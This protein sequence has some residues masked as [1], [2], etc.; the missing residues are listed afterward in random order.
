[1]SVLYINN[2]KKFSCGD[3]VSFTNFALQMENTHTKT[4][5]ILTLVD[6][7]ISAKY[8][9][10]LKIGAIQWFG[11]VVVSVVLLV[12]MEY[13][14][15]L[16][17]GVKITMLLLTSSTVIFELYWLTGRHWL[18][19]KGFLNRMSR[20]DAAIEL[21]EK[22]PAIQDQLLNGIQLVEAGKN[23]SLVE[24]AL[25]KKGL[26][27]TQIRLDDLFKRNV[28]IRWLSAGALSVL[29]ILSFYLMNPQ[30]ITEGSQRFFSI[31][32]HY[33]ETVPYEFELVGG[34]TRKVTQG[35]DE[36]LEIEFGHLIPEQLTLVKGNSRYRMKR[37][38]NRFTVVLSQ[39]NQSE[40]FY[41][42]DE[43]FDFGNGQIRVVYPPRVFSKDVVI[44]PPRYTGI[45]RFTRPDW[46]VTNIPEGST[47]E[48]VVKGENIEQI[49]DTAGV[50]NFAKKQ[51]IYTSELELHRDFIS[52][53]TI[54]SS[55]ISRDELIEL[56]VVKDAYPKLIIG[57]KSWD[58]TNGI[59]RLEGKA[60]DDYGVV[61]VSLFWKLKSDSA[62]NQQVLLQS[63][64][65]ETS[66]KGLAQVPVGQEVDAFVLVTDNDALRNGKKTKSNLLLFRPL[67]NKEQQK[68]MAK[69]S[70]ELIEQAK[71]VK[72]KFDENQDR[73]EKLRLKQKSGEKLSWNEIQEFKKLVQQTK[74]QIVEMEKQLNKFKQNA[75]KVERNQQMNEKQERMEK[76]LDEMLDEDTKKKLDELEK[77]L[78]ELN[79]K[80]DLGEELEEFKLT[81][82]E[83]D[84]ELDRNLELLKRLNVENQLENLAERLQDLAKQQEK[85]SR[86][87]DEDSKE[88]K[89]VKE[90][91]EQ[92]KEDLEETLKENE[93]LESPM[94]IDDQEE[95]KEEVGEELDKAEEELNQGEKKK[96]NKS[97]KS[98]S[99]KMK[100]MSDKMKSSMAS[101][102]S[103]QKQEDLESLRQTLDNLVYLSFEQ[104]KL[105]EI[106]KASE[107]NDPVLNQAVRTQ[108]KLL[109]D[110]K[111]IEDS[112]VALS[113][114]IAQLEP[115]IMKELNGLKKEQTRS[116][117]QMIDRKMQKNL[118][119]SQTAI[120]H[121]NNLAV[122]L[123]ELSQQM[124]QQMAQMKFGEG[125]CENPGSQGKPK[126]G[127]MKK[128]QQKINKQIEQLK[129]QMAEEGVKGNS[130]KGEKGS[131]GNK[132]GSSKKFAQMA[133]EQAALRK[134]V[135]DLQKAMKNGDGGSLKQLQDSMEKTEE[136]LLN[137]KI[138]QETLMRQEKILSRLLEAE[139]A[140]RE[141]EKEQKRESQSGRN[142][143]IY[144]EEL[145][146]YLREKQKEIEKIKRTPAEFKNYYKQK[147]GTYLKTDG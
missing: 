105:I 9:Y 116:L 99:D 48:V 52:R 87:V 122:M 61:D 26:L 39:I 45:E 84:I 8:A 27:S 145:E 23:S 111:V 88:Q 100:E 114:R 40:G 80:E 108:S 17:P 35:E 119:A 15:F 77:L 22:I 91:F 75:Q 138:S 121:I 96:A 30:I 59:F 28:F 107:G 90:E 142:R 24:A 130:G 54:A 126:A 74:S 14:F 79:K 123:D 118:V 56:K 112:L 12:L 128:M 50:L 67:S 70:K 109:D 57:S 95:Q 46:N 135:Q 125:A 33:T 25:Q 38:G 3:N 20:Q 10:Q 60:S 64:V 127:D 31:T 103:A 49:K 94:D 131:K 13:Y 133:A 97:Q 85:L 29:V 81:K 2:N 141:R 65:K 98:A 42:T 140:E 115:A 124:Q 43:K 134:M 147:A 72:E 93:D 66:W 51:E 37:N 117:E 110:A 143:D 146:K 104:E 83:F 129:K 53:L 106:A 120:T 47:V 82:E 6:E 7:Y 69:S 78:Q 18:A 132:G 89:A 63:E 92:I 102:Q 136:D 139:N 41:F 5:K 73:L 68:L 11:L 62:W 36:L 76:L 137:K 113:K 19:L 86:E 144:N 21:Q 101:S 44:S 16:P 58:P 71:S 34:E 32:T 1:M 55:E 4:P